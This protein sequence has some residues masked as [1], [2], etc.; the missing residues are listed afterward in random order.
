MITASKAGL[1]VLKVASKN[2]VHKAAKA[3]GEIIG[4][5]IGNKNVKPKVSPALNSRIIEEIIIAPKK[6]K[7]ILN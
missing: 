5:K 1:D 2:V 4:N 3:T 6:R 7:K